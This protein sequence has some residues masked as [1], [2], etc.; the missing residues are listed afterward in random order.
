[1]FKKI[2]SL[3]LALTLCFSLFTVKADE[4]QDINVYLSFSKDGEFAADKFGDDI[5]LRQITLSGKESYDINDVFLAMHD[6]LSENGQIAYAT[7]DGQWGLFIEKLWDDTSGK[8]GYY[9][10]SVPQMLT[11]PVENGDCIETFIYKSFYPDTES[12]AKFDTLNISAFSGNEFEL[13]LKC[14]TGYSNGSEIFSP[15]S[16]ATITIDGIE[17][18]FV[19]DENGK[20]VISIEENGT[21]IISAVKTKTLELS[22]EIVPAIT[23]PVC[24]AEISP[25][26]ADALIHNIAKSYTETDFSDMGSNLPW[27]VSDMI[28]YENI[29]PESDYVF[30]QEQKELALSILVQQAERAVYPGD[31]AKSIIAIRS[32]GFDASKI[33][34]KNFIKTDAPSKLISLMANSSADVA[35]IYTLPYVIIAL[36]QSDSFTSDDQMQTLIGWG[37]DSKDEWLNTD[38][39][40]D[41]LTPMIAALAPYYNTNDDVKNAIDE[42]VLTLYSEQR[43]DGLIDGFEGYESA[44]TGLAVCALSC[45]GIDSASVSSDGLSLI[46]GIIGTADENLTH[47]P[48]AFATEQGFRGLLV[49]KML[50]NR[51]DA[52]LYDFSQLP[53][54]EVNLSGVEFCPVYFSLTPSDAKVSIA[55]HTSI[56]KN[57]YDLTE[58][59]YT[60][61]VTK[62][63]YE[64]KEG[65]FTVTSADAENRSKKTISVTLNKIYYGGGTSSSKEEK[66]ENEEDEPVLPEAEK[67]VFDENTFSDVKSGSWYYDSVKYVYENNLFSGT[68]KGFEP[69]SNMTRAMLVTVLHRLSDSPESNQSNNFTDVKDG[70]WYWESVK[71]AT[72]TGIVKGISDKSFAPSENITREQLA[73]ILY[74]YSIM[75]GLTS[76][77]TVDISTYEDDDKI[78]EYAKDAMVYAV[79]V[80]LITGTDENTLMPNSTATRAEV[81]T[82]LMR[83]SQ[84]KGN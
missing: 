61:T 16:D 71:W 56:K 40:T 76:D 63:G 80:G 58:G 46:D 38:F 1:M 9:L 37:V 21:H 55:S 10:N 5:V 65:Q 49:W 77:E 44:S 8:F 53:M 45:L 50:Q 59:E 28:M 81:A 19:T 26:T 47:L 69:D 75:N 4:V 27:I 74:R 34:S 36:S 79:S 6:Q 67:A 84:M 30:S 60:Y 78:S 62:D 17:T 73:L 51:Q 66:E 18:E 11:T 23:A 22:E 15:C 39:G 83:F 13:T 12:Y 14:V 70:E 35:N 24:I 33:Y 7:S 42:A 48:N 3:V 54:A 64:G 20:S 68:D 25:K 82:I 52:K 31:V 41:G 43:S 72:E 2:L 57:L 29:F 32:L